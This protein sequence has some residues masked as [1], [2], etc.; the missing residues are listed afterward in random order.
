[1]LG[2]DKLNRVLEA[3]QI[4]R[5]KTFDQKMAISLGQLMGSETVLI[6]DI[7]AS[8]ESI[9][10]L[11]RLVDTGTSIILAEKDIYWEGGIDSGFR[12]SLDEVR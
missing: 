10:I 1:V 7:S 3:Q 11:A 8:Q 2:R 12:E 5:D 4:N 6:G 9:E